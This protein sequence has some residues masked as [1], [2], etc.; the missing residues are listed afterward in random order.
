V[1]HFSATG[2]ELL[3]SGQLWDSE[4]Q[5]SALAA[6]ADNVVNVCSFSVGPHPDIRRVVDLSTPYA[7]HVDGRP[8]RAV[9][10]GRSPKNDW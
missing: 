7:H 10:L 1:V 6:K 8:R 5:E 3:R 4:S 9:T 2:L